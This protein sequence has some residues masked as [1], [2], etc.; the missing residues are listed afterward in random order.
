MMLNFETALLTELGSKTGYHTLSSLKMLN[1]LL[2]HYA[3]SKHFDHNVMLILH[4]VRAAS[5]RGNL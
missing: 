3:G 1:E 5:H 4:R 2:I